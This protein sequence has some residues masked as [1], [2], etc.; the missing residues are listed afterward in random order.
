[1]KDQR[2]QSALDIPTLNNVALSASLIQS[3]HNPETFRGNKHCRRKWNKQ[4]C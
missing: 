2:L 4:C 3:S 1:M